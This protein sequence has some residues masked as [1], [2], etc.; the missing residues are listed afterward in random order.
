MKLL[1]MSLVVVTMVGVSHADRSYFFPLENS[2]YHPL[3]EEHHHGHQEEHHEEHHELQ[4]RELHEAVEEEATEEK[5]LTGPDALFRPRRQLVHYV[6]QG[7]EQKEET[8]KEEAE[9]ETD[10]VVEEEEKNGTEENDFVGSLTTVGLEQQEEEGEEFVT[11]S[12]AGEVDS[13]IGLR[14]EET[15]REE[16]KNVIETGTEETPSEDHEII[17]DFVRGEELPSSEVEEQEEE[18]GEGEPDISLSN[19][20]SMFVVPYGSHYYSQPLLPFPMSPSFPSLNSY[21]MSPMPYPYVS[22]PQWVYPVSYIP[23]QP[24]EEFNAFIALV[25]EEA[26]NQE[27]R[28]GGRLVD[29]I[30]RN[31][32]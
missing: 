23:K 16:N 21:V 30:P 6:P 12:Y 24:Y 20:Y 10:P 1:M 11:E 27:I 8:Q 17:S 25:N 19:F 4:E 31:Q 2:H 9:R 3:D 32:L 5:Q 29:G 13:A 7:E 28:R 26:E 22:S 14:E 18:G 15:E